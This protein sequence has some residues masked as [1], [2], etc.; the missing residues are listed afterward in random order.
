MKV[1]II[2]GGNSAHV[3]IPLLSSSGHDVSL[4]T[5]NPDQ[6]NK[7]IR[8]EYH[9]HNKECI[10]AWEGELSKISADPAAVTPDAEVILLCLPV[11]ANRI[12]LHK[13]APFIDRS[14]TIFLGTIYGQAGF[15]WMAREIIS[16][17]C[18]NN[19]VYFSFGLIPWI[20]R[21]A[22]YGKLG[23]T[24]GCKTVN[25]AAIS[26][27][28][29]FDWLNRNLLADLCENKFGVGKV[30]RAENFLSL[31]LSVDNQI[32][33]PTRCYALFL[34]FAGIWNSLNEVPYFYRDYDTLSAEYLQKLDADFSAVRECLKKIFPDVDFK[35]MLDYFS[36]EH[37]SYSSNSKDIISSFTES[38]TLGA[39][40]TPVVETEN[41]HW[42]IDYSHRFFKDDYTYGI[43]IA[44]WFAEKLAISTPTIDELI[45]WLEKIINTKLLNDDNDLL[46][47]SPLFC[48]EFYAGLPECYGL[49]SIDQC[50]E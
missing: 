1:L 39:I 28:D 36:L 17:F 27:P 31:T 20:T 26:E 34:Q 15:N 46:R 19:I 10:N 42:S 29:K 45:H 38:K 22:S 16:K 50:I 41:G 30:K 49:Q 13:I 12:M 48:K 47:D 43:C 32:I 25:I 7:H 33:H 18:L 24:Y 5:S 11:H 37:L 40:K 14:K 23:I 9:N 2:G 6:W 4:L 21:T 44:K 35:Y 8:A 3:L